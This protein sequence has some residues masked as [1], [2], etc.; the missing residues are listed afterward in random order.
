M[1]H[2]PSTEH[3]LII[4]PGELG[5]LLVTKV[6]RLKDK[7]MVHYRKEG[8]DL[9]QQAELIM[10]DL[11]GKY[12]FFPWDVY[13]I[14]REEMETKLVDAENNAYV[15]EFPA[16]N[17]DQQPVFV[18]HEYKNPIFPKELKMTIPIQ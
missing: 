18:T 5:R 10:E 11:E 12:N 1:E 7:T 4:P 13:I 14:P 6:E 3:P 16:L 17:P 9:L 15:T 2:E 8:N